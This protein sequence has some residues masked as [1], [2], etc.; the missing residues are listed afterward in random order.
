MR[1]LDED[2][3]A[4]SKHP[5]SIVVVVVVII[6]IIITLFQNLRARCAHFIPL[7]IFFLT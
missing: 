7:N 4:R 1:R 6:I 3:A 2:Q 5:V